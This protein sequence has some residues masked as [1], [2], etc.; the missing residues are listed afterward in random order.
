MEDPNFDIPEGWTQQTWLTNLVIEWPKHGAMTVDFDSRRF[1]LGWTSG[2]YGQPQ[3]DV[4]HGRGWQQ[5][6]VDDA[7][8]HLQKI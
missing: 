6:L 5:R 8:Q 3:T 2:V 1:G 4:Y 7:V